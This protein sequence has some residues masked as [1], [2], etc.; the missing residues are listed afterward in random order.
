M[1]RVVNSEN[2]V[3]DKKKSRCSWRE[4]IVFCTSGQKCKW[5]LLIGFTGEAS[6]WCV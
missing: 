3:S 2:I 1:D 6:T 4:N 5:N